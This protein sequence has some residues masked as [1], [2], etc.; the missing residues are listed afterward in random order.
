MNSK[1]REGP[2]I[3]P[4]YIR[5]PPGYMA[6]YPVVYCLIIDGGHPYSMWIPSTGRDRIFGLFYIRYPPGYMAGYPVVYCL[7]IDGC[8]PSSMWLKII[9]M[10]R[11][12]GHFYVFIWPDIKFSYR[13]GKKSCIRCSI[14]RISGQALVT[15]P[16]LDYPNQINNTLPDIRIISCP[17][18]PKS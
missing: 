18:Q 2:D 9:V 1:C 13:P 4:F 15:Y 11:I 7:I 8:H 12:F 16:V 17:V 5:Y 10:D 14:G 3:R 6:E